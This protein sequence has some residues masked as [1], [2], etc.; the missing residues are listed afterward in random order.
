MKKTILFTLIVVLA[1][2]AASAN[3]KPPEHP[4]ELDVKVDG[5]ATPGGTVALKLSLAP[6]PGIKINKY[7][8]IKFTIPAQDGVPFEA[9]AQLGNDQPPN[10]DAMDENYFKKISPLGLEVALDPEVAPGQHEMT[11]KIKYFYCVVE[12]G[13]CAPKKETLRFPLTVE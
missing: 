1:A 11:A 10:P 6:K 4:A 7:P 8:K 9:V 3:P 13:F 5:K 12:S 2:C